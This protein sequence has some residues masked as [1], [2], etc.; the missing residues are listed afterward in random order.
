MSITA[1]S[2]K[3][4]SIN[5]RDEVDFGVSSVQLADAMIDDLVRHLLNAVGIAS[6]YLYRL[7]ADILEYVMQQE[8]KLLHWWADNRKRLLRWLPN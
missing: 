5:P 8:T 2:L 6:N 7:W 1:P 4:F 3:E